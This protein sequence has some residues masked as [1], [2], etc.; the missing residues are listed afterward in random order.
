MYTFCVFK[1]PQELEDLLDFLSAND[2]TWN[3]IDEEPLRSYNTG[4][5]D[6][7]R[8]AESG[9]G[10]IRFNTKNFKYCVHG[11]SKNVSKNSRGY[12]E[13]FILYHDDYNMAGRRGEPGRKDDAC[14]LALRWFNAPH[15]E[16]L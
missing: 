2:A 15:V 4:M 3:G 13:V 14:S 16:Q 9:G 8:R 11:Q 6:L 5:R 12:R 1:T 10:Y 7:Q